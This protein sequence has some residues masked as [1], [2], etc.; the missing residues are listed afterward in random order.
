MYT[1]H[2]PAFSMTFSIVAFVFYVVFSNRNRP[3]TT[4]IASAGSSVMFVYTEV[5]F[6]HVRFGI[7]SVKNLIIGRRIG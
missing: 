6:D 4:T 3:R 5:M 7:L 1:A 2:I